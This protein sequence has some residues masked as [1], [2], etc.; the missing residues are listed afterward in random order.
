MLGC[1][2]NIPIIDNMA[3]QAQQQGSSVDVSNI[4]SFVFIGFTGS[5][6]STYSDYLKFRMEEAFGIKVYRPSFSQKIEEIARDLF[7]M[8]QYDRSLLQDI[9]NKL[10]ELDP[11]VWAKHIIRDLKANNKLPVVCDGLRKPE[12]LEAFRQALGNFVVIRLEADEKKLLEHYKA[13]YGRYPTTEQMTNPAETAI[14]SLHADMTLF[15]NYDKLDL[16]RQIG[17]VIEAIRTS[18]MQQLIDRCKAGMVYRQPWGEEIIKHS[19]FSNPVDANN[20]RHMEEIISET[21]ENK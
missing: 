20:W 2:K 19:K 13:K 11:A 3:E 7:G 16:D 12:E 1:A 6:K 14:A 4:P 21:T 10:R 8:A 18:T 15:N 5:G 17:A 9:G